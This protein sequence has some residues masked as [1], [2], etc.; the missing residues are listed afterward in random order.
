MI[1]TAR[2]EP[3]PS[4]ALVHG[5]GCHLT[6]RSRCVAATAVHVGVDGVYAGSIAVYLAGMVLAALDLLPPVVA[7]FVHVGS[8][9]ASSSTPQGSSRAASETDPV[10]RRVPRCSSL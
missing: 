4:W 6:P 3:P 2:S 5:R 7:A 10:I 8:E 9:T 1:G